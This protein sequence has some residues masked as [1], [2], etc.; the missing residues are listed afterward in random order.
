M[1]LQISAFKEWISNPQ[2]NHIVGYYDSQIDLINSLISYLSASMEENGICII[3][4]RPLIFRQ[5][6]SSFI[7]NH[8]DTNLNN[9]HSYFLYNAESLLEEFIVDG[10]L[11][12]DRF[13]FIIG[14]LIES[15]VNTGKNVRVY[16]DMVATLWERGDEDAA[17]ELEELWND[18]I[19][20]YS[21]SLY[22]A[23]PKSLFKLREAG[24]QTIN[25]AHN[26]NIGLLSFAT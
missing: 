6:Q 24:L 12:R 16:G 21:F 2:N 18:L 14:R 23:Y 22:C 10:K 17:M 8:I 26:C 15:S 13:H 20:S 3:I 11:D 4:T 9:N 25:D 7:R 19:D 5:L 1:E